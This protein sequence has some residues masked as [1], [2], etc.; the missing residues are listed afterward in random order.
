MLL[1]VR[2]KLSYIAFARKQTVVELI[3][4]QV[5]KSYKQ[6]SEANCIPKTEHHSKQLHRKYDSIFKGD[7]KNMF[8][9]IFDFNIMLREEEVARQ[10]R[11]RLKNNKTK[12]NQ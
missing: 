6:L 8:H 10:I 2:A 4:S 3:V 5:Y 7:M 12:D 11:L 9:H 1:R